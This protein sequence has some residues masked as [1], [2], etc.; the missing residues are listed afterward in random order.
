MMSLFDKLAVKG[1]SRPSGEQQQINPMRAMQ[2]EVG[3][4]K[5]HPGSYLKAK[6]FN[7]PDGMTDPGQITQYLIQSGQVGNGRYQMAMRMLNGMR[8]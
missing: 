1:P 7:I 2:N 5:S 3:Q 6:G 8:R 4:V